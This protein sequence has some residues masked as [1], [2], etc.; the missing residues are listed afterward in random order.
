MNGLIQA[1]KSAELAAA[2]LS[3]YLERAEDLRLRKALRGGSSQPRYSHSSSSLS[4]EPELWR[5]LPHITSSAPELRQRLT[6]S[7]SPL[8]APA[9]PVGQVKLTVWYYSEERKLV[10]IIHSCWA[11]RQNERDPPYPYVSLLL[12]PD[13][14]Q[15]TKRKT[16]QKKR[17]LN[18][19]FNERFEWELPL[20]EAFWRKLDVSVKSSSSFMSRECELLGKVQLDLAEIDLSQGA[21][22]WYDLMD[23]KD[24]GSS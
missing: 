18:P 12:L 21:V 2:L 6:R 14:N 9:G 10:S 8:E 4:E 15:G 17:T 5:G 7:D 1:Q 16:S 3:V 19:E 23:D 11:L 22:Q 13:K 24:K 20:D